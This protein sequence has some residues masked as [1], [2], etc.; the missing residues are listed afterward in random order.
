MEH[1]PDYVVRQGVSSLPQSLFSINLEG[2]EEVKLKELVSQFEDEIIDWA[3]TKADGQ[4]AKAAELLGLPRTTLQS[5]LSP[6]R[7]AASSSI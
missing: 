5:R 1:L 2:R 7:Q 4:Q 3:L 6:R